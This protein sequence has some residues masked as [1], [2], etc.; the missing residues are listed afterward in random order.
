[1]TYVNDL[2]ASL[3]DP[4]TVYA[5]LNN[6]KR[7]DFRPYVYKSTNRGR[8]WT[9]ITGDLPERGSVY[10]IVQDHVN[11]DLLFVGTEFGIFFTVDGGAKWIRLKGGMPTIAI[12]DLEIQRRE[13]DLVAASFGRGFFILDDYT[14]LRSLSDE[15]VQR[16]AHLFPVKTAWMYIQESPLG[17]SEKASQGAGFYTAP[18]PPFGATFTYYLRD[19]L[20]TREAQRRQRERA[21]AEEDR[22]VF[23]PSWD[24]LKAEDREE[25]PAIVLTV[26]DARGEVVRRL[27]G[28]TTKG[29]HRVTWDFRYPGYAPVSMSEDGRGPLALPGSYTV[30]LER[31][32]AGVATELVPPTP[33]E[34]VPLGA[35]SLP[36]ADREALLAFQ[37][38]TGELQ[39]AVLGASRAAGE[40]AE[41]I[42][43]IKRAIE[44]SPNVDLALRDEARALELRLMDLREALTGDPTKPRHNEPELPGIIGRVNQIVYG[45]W[46]STAAPTATHRRNYEIASQQFGAMV[47]DLRQLIEVDL[48]AFEQ[49]LEEAGVP[50]TPGRGVPRWPQP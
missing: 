25:E 6:H 34:V 12:R 26:R 10:A 14:P 1:M 41:R 27:S 21:L 3:H 28:K 23:Y 36:P 39:R 46:S 37:R 47:G 22:D 44:V 33:F 16:E 43:Y 15:L 48:P 11:P 18:N 49:R 7:G 35:P 19:S 20:Q 4:N 9:A 42:E 24:E 38:E 17:G 32:V 2:E 8:R 50:W 5:V 45:H 31:R 40:A 30:S 29:V 13:S